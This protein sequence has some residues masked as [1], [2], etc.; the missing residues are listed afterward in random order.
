MSER[1]VSVER[2][3]EQENMRL[4]LSSYHAPLDRLGVVLLRTPFTVLEAQPEVVLRNNMFLTGG[5]VVPA[6]E[7]E[8]EGRRDRCE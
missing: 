5:L 6:R 7:V 1:L 3:G 2:H 4:V 8:K